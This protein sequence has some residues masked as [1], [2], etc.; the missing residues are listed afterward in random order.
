MV[1][2]SIVYRLLGTEL[3]DQLG[4]DCIYVSIDDY[5]ASYCISEFGSRARAKNEITHLVVKE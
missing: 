3:K 2:L 1:F 4:L 5:V